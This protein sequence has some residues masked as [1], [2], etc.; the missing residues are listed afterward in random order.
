MT[1]SPPHSWTTPDD[2]RR[3]MS[4]RWD[5]GALLAEVAGGPTIFPYRFRLTRP[6]ITELSARY[7]DVRTW[8][9]ALVG[10]EH[11]RVVTSAQ[12]SRSIGRNDIPSEVWVD[13]IEDAAALI[14][15][16]EQLAHFRNLVAMT[17]QPELRGW[18][19]RR[20]MEAAAVAGSWLRLL[21][22]VEW[23]R[24]HPRPQ[25]YLRQVDIPGVDTKFIE[26]HAKVLSSMI[27]AVLPD[28]VADA[29]A[30]VFERRFGF[31][32]VPQTVRMRALDTR[33]APTGTEDRPVTLTVEDFARLSGVEYVFVTEN[34]T[35][36]LAFPAALGSIVVFG[37][38][39]DVAKIAVAP[40]IREVPVYYWGDIDTHGFAILDL[41]R[42]K[43]PHVRSLLMDHATLHAH[44]A[45]WGEELG[46]V[47]R[48]LAHLT[49]PER[50]LYD[51]LRDNRIR[52]NLRLEQELT[53]FRLIES[54]V[55]TIV[56]VTRRAP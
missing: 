52:P 27:D 44:E 29:G 8:A 14:G 11:V 35:N 10:T 21:A 43:L 32:V 31:R 46:Q 41:L 25:I 53:R 1:T 19:A 7:D 17:P 3:V 37:E 38:G 36:F 34:Y 24:A 28:T 26:R 6:A 39:Y 22:V 9:R 49:R 45:Q 20:P 40:W 12:G 33:L 18:M 55:D 16:S 30:T 13:G 15:A 42:S 50:D 48:D 2:L 47:R 56:H 51:D 23:M 5:E 4:R 54:A